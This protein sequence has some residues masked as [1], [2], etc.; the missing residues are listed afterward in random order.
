MTS[1]RRTAVA[2]EKKVAIVTGANRGLGRVVCFGLAAHGYAVVMAGPLGADSPLDPSFAGPAAG[3]SHDVAATISERGGTALGVGCDLARV[4]DIRN[5]VAAALDR[6]GRIDVLVNNAGV[7]CESRVV[8]LDVDLL[9]RCLAV[10]VRAPLLLGKFALPA[11]R[12]RKAGSVIG[13]ASGSSHGNRPGHVMESL[14]RA[15]LER[16]FLNLAEEVRPHNIAVNLLVTGPVERVT[17]DVGGR[18]TGHVP[19]LRTDTVVP[20]VNWLAAQTATRF[21]GHVVDRADF[22]VTWGA[23]ASEAF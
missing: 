3:T 2:E 18:G 21:T 16:M 20:V 7:D 22:G 9:D 6:F 19:P 4:D 12:A 5:L 11:M 17:R 15:A 1:A 14:S 13:I 8:D 10:N 23:G